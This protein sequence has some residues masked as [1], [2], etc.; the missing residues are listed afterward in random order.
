MT[1]PRQRSGEL[2]LEPPNTISQPCKTRLLLTVIF[3]TPGF[4]AGGFLMV[5]LWINFYP[6]IP[7]PYNPYGYGCRSPYYRR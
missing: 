1:T 6:S 4:G 2:S 3:L 5:K 7:Y